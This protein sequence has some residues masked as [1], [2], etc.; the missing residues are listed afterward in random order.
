MNQGGKYL[1][2][3][4]IERIQSLM[5]VN[6]LNEQI[7]LSNIS[8]FG[9]SPGGMLM[10]KQAL[11]MTTW[12]AHDWLTFVDITAGLLGLIPSPAAPYLLGISTAACFADGGLYLYEGDDYMG[13][14]VLS[15]CLIPASE[16]ALMGPRVSRSMAKGK[17]HVL[18]TIKK[19]RDLAD[20]AKKRTLTQA[21]KAIVKE[22]D[23]LMSE[24]TQ[25]TQKIANL[26]QKHLVTRVVANIL[27]TG[28]KLLFG[29]VLLLTKMSWS[30]GKLG[31]TIGGIYYTYD[32]VYIA[33]YGTDEEKMKLRQDSSFYKL[34]QFLKDP[35]IKERVVKEVGDFFNKHVQMFKDNPNLLKQVDCTESARLEQEHQETMRELEE[36]RNL[37]NQMISPPIQDVLAGKID[38]KT[39]KPYVIELGQKG[40]SVRKVQEMLDSLKYGLTLRGYNTEKKGVDGDFGNNTFDA[41]ILFQWNNELEE[42]GVVDSKTLKL[43][44]TKSDEKKQGNEK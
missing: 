44:K 16:L 11:W 38:P 42:T 26:T 19:G 30:L 17:K 39:K 24:L 36:K 12:D 25:N 13:G 4:E 21:E 15:F 8:D 10:T 6:V 43:L 23:E 1:Y 2:E 20:L 29:T 40:E 14:L 22:A 35:K 41:V 32:E 28:G 37:E 18:D 33:L 7:G 3:S 27:K 5:G 9:L 31:F 34:V